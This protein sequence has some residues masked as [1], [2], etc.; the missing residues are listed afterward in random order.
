MALETYAIKPMRI[1]ALTQK[2]LAF[3]TFKRMSSRS[4]GDVELYQYQTKN[5]PKAIGSIV[6][7][8]FFTVL[9]KLD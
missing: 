5:T 4:S 8:V 9:L 7:K 3:L 1:D 6:F 2:G